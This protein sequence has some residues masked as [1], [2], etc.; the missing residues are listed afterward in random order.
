[1]GLVDAWPSKKRNERSG[2]MGGTA[3]PA[4]TTWIDLGRNMADKI[5]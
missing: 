2:E 4:P 3:L 1:M 5:Y